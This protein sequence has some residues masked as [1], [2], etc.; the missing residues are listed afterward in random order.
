[1]KSFSISEEQIARVLGA[2][3]ADELSRRFNKHFDFLTIASWTGETA[4]G[5][6]GLD[7]GNEELTAC[8]ERCAV[9]FGLDKSFFQKRTPANFQ[10]AATAIGEAVSEKLEFF[11]FKSAARDDDHAER[12]HRADEIYQDAAAAANV[13][14]GRRRLLSLVAPHSLMG[15]EL[16]ILTPNLQGIETIDARG[17]TPEDLSSTLAY[18]D[19]LIAT[20]TLWRYMMR[21]SLTSPDNTMAVSFGEAMAP[22]LAADMRKAGFGVLRELYGSTETGLMGW[23]DAPMEPFVLFDHWRHENGDPIRVSPSGEER[24]ATAM[25]FLEWAGP[26]AFRIAG[27]LDGAVQV[28]AV[29]VQPQDVARQL[30]QHP[31]IADCEIRVSERGD[32]VTRLVAHIVLKENAKPDEKTARDIDAWCRESLRQQE[33]PRIFHFHSNTARQ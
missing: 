15:F 7:L 2:S 6:G 18:G 5:A 4:F 27:R 9:L 31:A 24:P 11:T 16:T 13:L 32:G 21:E 28:G 29:N 19:V 22:D 25:D 3:F 12:Q 20:P 1:V 17:I 14:Y 33:R 26:R 10:D 8:A 30:A 23:R